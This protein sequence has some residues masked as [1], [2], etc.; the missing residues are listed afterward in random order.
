M[1]GEKRIMA[2]LNGY[3]SGDKAKQDARIGVANESGWA[4]INPSKLLLNHNKTM[5]HFQKTTAPVDWA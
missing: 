4:S 3:R 2:I 5:C 1:V